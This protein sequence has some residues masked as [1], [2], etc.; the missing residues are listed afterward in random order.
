VKVLFDHGVD[1]KL[2]KAFAAHEVRLAKELGWENLSNGKLLE[3]AKNA[4][5]HGVV[6]TDTKSDWRMAATVRGL[7]GLVLRPNR[8]LIY[9]PYGRQIEERFIQLQPGEVQEF[10]VPESHW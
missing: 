3:A 7:R 10:V 5:Y 9:L 2:K 4:G 8:A 1:A 6:T